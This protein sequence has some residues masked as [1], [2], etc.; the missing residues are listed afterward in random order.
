MTEH[1]HLP[2]EEMEVFRRF[3]EAADWVW[4]Q[5]A[6]WK[7]FARDT[8]GKQM[9]RAADSVGANLVEG[10]GRY[11]D[12]DAMHFF[13]IARASARETQY[14]LR[15]AVTRGILEADDARQCDEKLRT[16][17][18]LLNKLISYRRSRMHAK[19]RAPGLPTPEYLNTQHQNTDRPAQ[20][21]EE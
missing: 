20:E 13:I 3:V 11:T 14:W 18:Q 7:P 2:M 5:V 17:T 6:G 9:V 19:H 16:A 1:A 10:D 4:R 8:I 21:V 12:A 15:R